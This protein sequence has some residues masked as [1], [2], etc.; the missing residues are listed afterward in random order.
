MTVCESIE[1]VEINPEIVSIL[2]DYAGYN[3]N[4]TDR[5]GVSVYVG[6]GRRFLE[7]SRH[8]YDMI[9]LTI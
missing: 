3:G 8:S 4:L 7:Q 5:E 1:A 9:G 2:K 6:D